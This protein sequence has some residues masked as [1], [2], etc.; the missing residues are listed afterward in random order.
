MTRVYHFFADPLLISK[1]AIVMKITFVLPCPS[2]AGGIRVIGIYAEQLQQRGHE[3]TLVSVPDA[4]PSWRSQVK[5]LLRGRGFEHHVSRPPSH[6]DQLTMEHRKLSRKRPIVDADVPDADVVIATWWETANWV[7]NL[8][9]A[10]GKK[11]YLLQHYEIFDYLPVEQVKATWKLPLHKIVV[12]QWLADLA[13][14]DYDDHQ[15]S[16]IPNGIDPTLFFAVPR[17][18]QAVPTVGLV[19][20]Q[21]YWKGSDIALQAIAI[22]QATVPQL[23]VVGFGH[24]PATDPALPAN[25]RYWQKPAQ[26]SL[27]SIYAQCDAWLFSS[28]FEGFGLPILEAMACRTPVIGSPAGAAP[29]LLAG[30]AG[31]LVQPE[32]PEDMARAI[33]QM[34]Q[35]SNTDWQQMSDRAYDR[36]AGYTWAE[37]TDELEAVFM[38]LV[39]DA[40]YPLDLPA[41]PLYTEVRA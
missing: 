24:G 36:V 25:I 7:A 30:G 29:E 3:V 13:A 35:M 20:S 32:N 11:A 17:A 5:S 41:N 22:A 37:A 6:L 40:P 16:C 27:S 8:S 1:V 14:Q 19:Y 18:K 23:R 9:P 2:F 10:K 39:D 4:S 12:A 31:M 28:R 38:N 34:A 21:E 33:V 15:V 26:T